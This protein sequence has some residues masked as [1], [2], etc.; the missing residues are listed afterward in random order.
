M[1]LLLQSFFAF[2]QN[3]E[4]TGWLQFRGNNGNGV[5]TEKGL[6]QKWSAQG[7]E[8]AWEKEM[9]NGFSEITVNNDKLFVMFGKK[10]LNS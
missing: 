3:S 5:S 7:P 8:L 2:A 4:K 6:L 1:L 10:I 9:G